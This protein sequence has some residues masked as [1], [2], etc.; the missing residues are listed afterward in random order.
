MC[1]HLG[2]G[3]LKR[4]PY[5]IFTK[6][7]SLV[8]CTEF[9]V[10]YPKSLLLIDSLH[11]YLSSAI[12]VYVTCSLCSCLCKYFAEAL[13][14]EPWEILDKNKESQYWMP[15]PGRHSYFVDTP[16]SLKRF[17]ALE[18]RYIDIAFFCFDLLSKGI[19]TFHFSVL[20]SNLISCPNKL[21]LNIYWLLPPILSFQCRV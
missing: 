7:A 17:V 6:A 20:I 14:I 19:Q 13:N 3:F 4:Q 9:L 2:S 1:E 15:C 18:K 5:V 10:Y 8:Q 21:F 12:F 11:S 16:T